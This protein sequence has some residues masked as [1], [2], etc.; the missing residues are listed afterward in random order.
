MAYNLMGCLMAYNV[1]IKIIRFAKSGLDRSTPVSHT[2]TA[3]KV[4]FILPEPVLY[5]E[6]SAQLVTANYESVS[7]FSV[8]I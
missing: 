7:L 1:E 8:T 4:L 2:H 3:D 6:N 5:R